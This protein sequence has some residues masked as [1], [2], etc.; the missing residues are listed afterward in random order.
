M[1]RL[2]LRNLKMR[3]SAKI[4]KSAK[5]SPCASDVRALDVELH[6]PN[7]TVVAYVELYSSVLCTIWLY[8]F[9]HFWLILTRWPDNEEAQMSQMNRDWSDTTRHATL[10]CP[11]YTA[12]QASQGAR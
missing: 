10:S 7:I 4:K 6:T 12:K 3:S 5:H 9:S 8:S 2:K 1:P 11:R